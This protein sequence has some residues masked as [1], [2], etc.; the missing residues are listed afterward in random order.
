[1]HS[2]DRQWMIDGDVASLT[3]HKRLCE[4]YPTQPL[5]P[6]LSSTRDW[7]TLPFF[8]SPSIPSFPPSSLPSR[9]SL[10]VPPFSLSASLYLPQPPFSSC[11]APGLF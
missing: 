9:L 11:L 10:L 6:H 1:M 4:P 7:P 2:A 5:S 8:A 3:G